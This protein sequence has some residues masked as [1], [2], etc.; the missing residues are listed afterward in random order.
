MPDE[1]KRGVDDNCGR[2]GILRWIGRH[3]LTLLVLIALVAMAG[4]GFVELANEVL[5]GK[6]RAM[7]QAILLAMRSSDDFND[8]IGPRWFEEMMRDFTALGGVGVLT[9]ITLSFA[10]FL[11]LQRK[12]HAAILLLFAVG[13]GTLLSFL[14]K[15]S[16][17]H[18]RPDLVPHESYVVTSSFP[19]SHSMMSAITYLTLGALLAWTQPHRQIKAYLLILAI[20][21][22]I[23]VGISRV[24]LGVHWPTDVLAGWAAGGIWAFFCWTVARW[25]QQR[26]KIKLSSET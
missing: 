5:E 8:P 9:F 25:L 4:W 13:G 6:A 14:L 12:F 7:D 3:E 15:R 24:Y 11:A 1:V 19:S 18:P 16:F 22:T 2:R 21:L 23:V 20:A 17:D 26:G 10:G